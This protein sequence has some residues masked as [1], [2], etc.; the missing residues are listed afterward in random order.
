[1]DE[2]LIDVFE[3]WLQGQINTCVSGLIS[4]IERLEA[5]PAAINSDELESK[6]ADLVRDNVE[7]YEFVNHE[8]MINFIRNNVSVE[9]DV[10][11]Y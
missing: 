10:S 9:L 2:K 7:E 1:M 8:E 5:A 6:I 4:R 11:R 3:R